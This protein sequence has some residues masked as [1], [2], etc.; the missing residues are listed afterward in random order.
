MGRF[1]T[2][3][4]YIITDRR[5]GVLYTDVTAYLLKRISQHR[6][7]EGSQFAAKYNCKRLA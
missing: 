6:A 3:A 7:G 4:V 5:Y 1:E 2:C